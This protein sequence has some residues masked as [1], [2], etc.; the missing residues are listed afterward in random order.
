L[1]EIAE[2]LTRQVGNFQAGLQVAS[3]ALELNPWYSVWLWN[4]YGD[5]L[6][7]LERFTDA[8]EAYLKASRLEPADART[9]LNLG[10]TFA[11]LGEPQ[12]ALEA[13]GRGLAGDRGGLFQERLLRKQQ[14]ILASLQARFA[15]EQEWLARRAARVNAR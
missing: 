4:V 11:Q 5:A 2:F 14:Q 1:G 8:H 7:A 15:E 3:S 6:Y 13:L 10:Y 12:S 9:N